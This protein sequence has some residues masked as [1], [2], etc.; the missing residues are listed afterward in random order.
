MFDPVTYILAKKAGG[1]GGGGSGSV[2]YK[3]TV[4]SASDLPPSASKGDMYYITG[5]GRIAI[6]DGGWKY[7]PDTITN[8]QIDALF[9]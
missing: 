4:A 6:Y 7:D 2:D 8:A 1:G 3:G 5:E 9:S